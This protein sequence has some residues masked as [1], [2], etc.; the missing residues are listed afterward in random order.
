ML[1]ALRTETSA[2]AAMADTRQASSLL[3]LLPSEQE[4]CRTVQDLVTTAS[5]A[6]TTAQDLP[7]VTLQART[8]GTWLL[9]LSF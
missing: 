5:Q 2:S 1:T 6:M 7:G 8:I 9:Q 4:V 3:R